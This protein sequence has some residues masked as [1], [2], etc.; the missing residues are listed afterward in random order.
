[1]NK[2]KWYSFLGAG[3]ILILLPISAVA[4]GQAQI[5]GMDGDSSPQTDVPIPKEYADFEVGPLTVTRSGVS[6]GELA[7]VAATVTNTGGVGGIYDAVLL[8]DG[9]EA[10]R[11]NVSVGPNSA[12]TVTFQVTMGAAGIYKLEIEKSAAVLTVYGWPYTIQY[13]DGTAHGELLSVS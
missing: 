13:D 12:A 8:I 7:T 1:M 4:C 9:K 11:K 10:D 6:V 2:H 3:L 5:P